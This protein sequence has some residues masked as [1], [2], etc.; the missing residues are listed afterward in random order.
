M[1][2]EN[3][4]PHADP[5]PE[6]ATT[7][8]E[9]AKPGRDDCNLAMLAH[10]LAIIGGVIAP[11]IIWIIK[12]DQSPY[13]EQ[14]AREALNFQITVLIVYILL[15]P[16]TFV[17]CGIAG[18][19]YIPVLVV[20]IVFCIIAALAANQGQHYTYPISLRFVQ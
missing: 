3:N 18:F 1:S 10:L 15:I 16:L 13:I 14:H 4:Q 11:L 12:K 2:P 5:S 20:D 17:T 9:P 6:S 7:P 19:L 8:P